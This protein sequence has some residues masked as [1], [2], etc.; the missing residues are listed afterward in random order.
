MAEGKALV[1]LMELGMTGEEAAEFIEGVKRGLKARREG[2][3][4][5]W[6][7]VNLW[8]G[9]GRFLL[10]G[11]PNIGPTLASSILERFGKIP[12]S[13]NC[14]LDE[15]KTVPGMGERRAEALWKLLK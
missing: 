7:E 9:F 6:D 4:W 5:P 1:V 10:Q 15:L 13:W 11:F 8:G 2:R 12:L 3:G 14:T